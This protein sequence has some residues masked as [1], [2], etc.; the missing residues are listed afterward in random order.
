MGSSAVNALSPMAVTG[1]KVGG[2]PGI[3]GDCGIE[4]GIYAHWRSPLYL[5]LVIVI[6]LLGLIVYSKSPFAEKYVSAAAD[7]AKAQTINAASENLP[8]IE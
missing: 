4:E 7:T 3:T 1:K 2:T 5:Y 8:Q 6:S